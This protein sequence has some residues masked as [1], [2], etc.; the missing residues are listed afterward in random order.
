[1]TDSRKFMNSQS[2]DNPQPRLDTIKESEE[3]ENV[4]VSDNDLDDWM[5]QKIEDGGGIK[6]KS[7][8]TLDPFADDDDEDMTGFTGEEDA[9]D[10][11]GILGSRRIDD[12]H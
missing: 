11:L 7:K 2:P 8:N 6:S 5:F 1:M 3:T 9:A 4:P 12:F 10:L